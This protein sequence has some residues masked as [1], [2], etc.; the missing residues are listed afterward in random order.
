MKLQ[1]RKSTFR[2]FAL[3]PLFL[4]SLNVQAQS[5]YTGES[6]ATRTYAITNATIVQAP[7]KVMEGATIVVSN[8]LITSVGKNVNAP[9][10]AEM[11]DG[12][13]MYIYPGFIDGMSHTGTKQPEPMDRPNNLFSPDPPNDYAGITPENTVISQVQVDESSISNMRKA[14]F[15]ISHSVPQGRMLP[16]SGAIIMLSDADHP[17]EMILKEES[18]MFTQ[19]AGAPRAYPG[20]TLGIM[21]KFR[22]LY[23]NAELAKQHAEMY[24]DNPAGLPRPN[25]DRVLEAFYPV[26]SNERPIFYDAPTALEARRAMRLKNELGFTLT[27]GNLEQG[28]DLIDD[29][30]ASGTNVFMSIDIPTEPKDSK[31]ED[32]SD[33]VK[34]LEERRME[35]YNKNLGQYAAMA[36]AGVKFGISSMGTN[37]NKVMGNMRTIIEH[38]LSENDALAA[39]TINSAQLLGIADVAGT[40]EGGKLGNMIVSNGPL[41]DEKTQIKYV[42]VD[43]DKYSYEIKEKKAADEGGSN[44]VADVVGEWSYS[45]QGPQGEASGKIIVRDE[46]GTLEATLTNDSGQPDVELKNVSY[47]SSMLSFDYD[48]DAGG[49]SIN[50]VFEGTVNGTDLEGLL[51]VTAFNV[52]IPL[53]A[54]KTSSPE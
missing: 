46:G 5:D 49:Q 37:A 47:A 26:V 15:T 33:E 54:M 30:K 29:L 32:K 18:S 23:K 45:Y 43:G 25:R 48:F 36:E 4:M 39:L 10:N 31:D 50:I 52:T 1:T 2:L 14:G 9:A 6:P 22:N 16:G 19:F 8:G 42:F 34:A 51:D 17:D 44:D 28:W 41:F 38:G 21:A 13:D 40:L 24:E 27:I 20:N 11:I 53:T 35:F 3:L 12:T 7:G